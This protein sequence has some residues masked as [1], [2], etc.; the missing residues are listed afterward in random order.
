M[1]WNGGQGAT[2]WK[3]ECGPRARRDTHADRRREVVRA[4]AP[5]GPGS[6]GLNFLMTTLM[7]TRRRRRGGRGSGER[8]G[9]MAF[10]RWLHLCLDRD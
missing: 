8:T 10:M 2:R 3:L 7:I 4:R 1:G 9:E 6:D 5:N